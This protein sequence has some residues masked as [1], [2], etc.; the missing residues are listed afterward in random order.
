MRQRFFE[1]TERV[2]NFMDPAYDKPRYLLPRRLEGM[3]KLG[4]KDA[5]IGV[6]L[7]NIFNTKYDNNGWADP[8]YKVATDGSVTAYTEGDLYEAGF[9]PSAPF[10]FMAHLSLNF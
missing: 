10:N 7:Y 1:S 9:A 8:H 4:I 5:K 6:S 3:K 2:D